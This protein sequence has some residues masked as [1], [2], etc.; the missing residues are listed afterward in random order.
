MLEHLWEPERM[1]GEC[2]RLLAPH[3]RLLVSVPT[4]LDK[5]LLEFVAFKLHVNAYE[6]EDHKRYYT[7]RALWVMLRQAGFLPSH[8]RCFKYKFGLAIFAVC[9]VD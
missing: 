5:P 6:I 4:W 7:R 9:D 1:L 8:I 3:G 2:H